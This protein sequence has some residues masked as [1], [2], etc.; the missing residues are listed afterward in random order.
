M[1]HNF[2]CK[3]EEFEEPKFLGRPFNLEKAPVDNPGDF[4]KDLKNNGNP[5]SKV[6]DFDRGTTT[7]AF[8]YQGGAIIAVDSRASQG[9]FESSDEVFKIIP[10]NERIVGTMAGG[11]AD[12]LFYLKKLAMNVK[13]YELKY[14]ENI[15]IAGA[16][17]LLINEIY[18]QKGKNLSIG[19]TIV[20]FDDTGVHI[21][22]CDNDGNR[23]EGDMFANG[24]GMTFA[25]GILDNELRWD[26][27]DEEAITLAKRACSEATYLDAGSGGRTTIAHVYPGGWKL[28]GEAEDNSELVWKHRKQMN[29][30]PNILSFA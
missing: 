19:S 6:A 4:V 3:S 11:A 7:L 29:V 30:K 16:S 24:S 8:R 14:G 23:M 15:N 5:A 17:S 9:T 22:Q 1:M 10:M 13:L 27:T 21:Y 2:V 20:G 28:V 18:S 26:M 12:C 25:L